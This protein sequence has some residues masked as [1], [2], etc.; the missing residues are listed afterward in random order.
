M[1]FL[2]LQV[3]RTSRFLGQIIRWSNSNPTLMVLSSLDRCAHFCVLTN[4]DLVLFVANSAYGCNSY[5]FSFFPNALPPWNRIRKI[6]VHGGFSIAQDLCSY[7][8][9]FRRA[10]FP[11]SEYH[12]PP[13]FLTMEMFSFPI[14]QNE[15]SVKRTTSGSLFPLSLVSWN[16][17]RYMGWD[18]FWI[19]CSRVLARDERLFCSSTTVRSGQ[20]QQTFNFSKP[21]GAFSCGASLV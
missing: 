13:L 15:I 5:I 14:S 19:S 7:S 3:A 10:W 12:P 17:Q 9:F 18:H 4:T 1:S 8:K 20:W 2:V 21:C 16:G 6:D 11:V